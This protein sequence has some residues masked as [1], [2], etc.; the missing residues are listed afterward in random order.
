MSIGG[1][2]VHAN[3]NVMAYVGIALATENVMQTLCLATI[4]Y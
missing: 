2:D 3:G 1:V 4:A